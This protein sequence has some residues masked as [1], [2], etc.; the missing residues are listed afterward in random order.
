MAALA[1]LAQAKKRLNIP[2]ATTTDDDEI[3]EFLDDATFIAEG[4]CDRTWTVASR[5]QTFDGGS[6][7]FVLSKSPVTSITSV[8]SNGVALAASAYQSDLAN[9][10]VKTY[11]P[12]VSGL[13]SVSIVYVVGE[14]GTV[15]VG[16]RKG[17]LEILAHLWETQRGNR[18]RGE[19]Y[20]AAGYVLPNRAKEAL[21]PLRN[22]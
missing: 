2:T 1:T 11:S 12:T 21:D 7:T 6:T 5:T 3:T 8:T 20:M 18:K 22:F 19:E 10:I 15:P 17:C 16:A 14:A 13:A 9:G 4:Y